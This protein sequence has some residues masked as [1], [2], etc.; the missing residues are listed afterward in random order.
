MNGKVFGV[1]HMDDSNILPLA[2]TLVAISSFFSPTFEYRNV[3]RNQFFR[4][5]LILFLVYLFSALINGNA[6]TSWSMIIRKLS[7]IVVPLVVL[8]NRK[9]YLQKVKLLG[10]AY[11]SGIFLALTIMDIRAFFFVM[12]EGSIPTYGDYADVFHPTYFGLHLLLYMIYNF[13]QILTGEWNLK[14]L[15]FRFG[16]IVI[17]IPHILLLLSKGVIISCTVVIAFYG[18]YLAIVSWRKLLLYIAVFGIC[19]LSALLVV[20]VSDSATKMLKN[21][22]KDLSNYEHDSGSTS[23]RAAMIKRSPEILESGWL[24]G[25]GY[26]NET[27]FL[28]AYYERTDW[29][30]AR[31]HSFNTHNQFLQTWLG[32]GVTG[33]FFLCVLMFGPF[34]MPIHLSMKLALFCYVFIFCTEA[35]LERQAGIIVFMF[36]Y[37][38]FIA[39][40]AGN[41]RKKKRLLTFE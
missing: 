9:F 17:L 38:I 4:L 14:K 40:L 36:F 22:F 21:R 31:L 33:L 5:F 7:F 11:A 32:L 13:H 18:V 23:F 24:F 34:M 1:L 26:G 6:A 8:G 20:P 19:G 3:F 35:V 37:S 27:E 2:L 10:L 15:L 29:K 41:R 16:L 39:M 28:D 30:Y 25:V 12:E